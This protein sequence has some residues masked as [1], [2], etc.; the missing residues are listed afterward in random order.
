M[1]TVL[2]FPNS[3]SETDCWTEWSCILQHAAGW[4]RGNKYFTG[5]ILFS[6][7]Q[8]WY[9]VLETLQNHGILVPVPEKWIS[10]WEYVITCKIHLQ[11]LP[12]TYITSLVSLQPLILFWKLLHIC[13]RL[14][15]PPWSK[16][17]LEISYATVNAEFEC[18]S[19]NPFQ[20]KDEQ[21]G[22]RKTCWKAQLSPLCC[23]NESGFGT[24][25]WLCVDAQK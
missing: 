9:C 23:G 10:G 25:S 11:I 16:P 22:R 2:Q 13:T 17:W 18:R 5:R 14:C 6:P 20:E 12:A 21:R 7:Q 1:V 24:G 19:S 3:E 15:V 4:R 8:S